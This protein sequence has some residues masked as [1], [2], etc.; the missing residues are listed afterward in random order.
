MLAS[1][2]FLEAFGVLWN[3]AKTV[4]FPLLRVTLCDVNLELA[5]E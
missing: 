2:L 5:S 3:V 1:I 4:A